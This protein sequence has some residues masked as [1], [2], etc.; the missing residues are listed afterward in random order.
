M[1]S[2]KIPSSNDMLDVIL[3]ARHVGAVTVARVC[4]AVLFFGQTKPRMYSMNHLLA[5][6]WCILLLSG[7][8]DVHLG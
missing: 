5:S 8:R 7:R 3:I 1:T 6:S 4:S 2:N